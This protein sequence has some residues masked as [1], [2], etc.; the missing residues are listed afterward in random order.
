MFSGREQSTK[1][2]TEQEQA[3]TSLWCDM[4]LHV[5]IV[6]YVTSLHILTLQWVPLSTVWISVGTVPHSEHMHSYPVSVLP[7][8][9]YLLVFNNLEINTTPAVLSKA[10]FNE[11]LPEIQ[12]D[13]LFWQQYFWY[14]VVDRYSIGYWIVQRYLDMEKGN[15]WWS[16]LYWN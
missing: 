4:Q 1:L 5:C 16:P 12:L 2:N 6:L 14:M 9:S 11:D 10:F 7:C 3:T 15:F 13:I 8:L